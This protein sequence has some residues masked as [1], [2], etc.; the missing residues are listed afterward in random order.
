M[1]E[2]ALYNFET[3]ANELED[4][5]NRG[6]FDSNELQKIIL[7]RKKHEMRLQRYDKNLFDILR[8]IESERALEKI[9]DKRIK[10]N[11]FERTL[12]DRKMSE[13]I[14]S[15]YKEALYRYDDGNI[16]TEFAEYVI[17]KKLF[18]EMKDTFA[19]YCL[20][21]PTDIDLW[22]FCASKLFLVDDVDSARAMFFKA[23]RM[24]PRSVRLRIEFFRMEVKYVQNLIELNLK[25]GI[26]DE[27]KDDVE[28]GD[29][30]YA[31]FMDIVS[32][33]RGDEHFEEILNISKGIK[34]LF[35]KIKT[36]INDNRLE[37]Q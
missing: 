36:F 21:H 16:I 23:I 37:N 1:I 5:K 12:N 31:I 18:A 27:D 33:S 29:V 20:K 26:D 10:K 15:L 19:S 6:I 8:Y 28:K 24:N 17:K 7:T 30:A 4:Y 32:N 9:R 2:R 3:M 34:E 25:L 13:R 35:E 22:I 11:N 14:V